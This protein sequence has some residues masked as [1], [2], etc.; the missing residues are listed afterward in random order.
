[1]GDHRVGSAA[2]VRRPLIAR[3]GPAEPRTACG[4]AFDQ[5]GGPVVAVVG[6]VGGAG[7]STISHALARQAAGESRAPVLLTESDPAGV[8]LAALTGAVSP[9]CL[10][11]LA[12]RRAAGEPPG[13]SF[14][15]P[16]PGFRVLASPQRRRWSELGDEVPALLSEARAAHGLVVIDCGVIGAR[17][18]LVTAAVTHLLWA[19]PATRIAVQR[20]AVL[21]SHGLLPTPGRARE[22]LVASAIQPGRGASARQLRQLAKSRCERLVLVPYTSRDIPG[23]PVQLAPALT[24]MARFLRRGLGG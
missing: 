2:L 4:L 21:S 24:A 1:M 23:H 5:P 7:T 6:L 11:E 9:M 12:R 8:G 18:P 14:I 15:E 17:T 22:A 10:D 20:A 16:E 13:R 3:G 19:L